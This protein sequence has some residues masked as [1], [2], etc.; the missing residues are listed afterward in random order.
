ML[1][2]DL[3]ITIFICKLLTLIHSFNGLLC[4]FLD[5]HRKVLLA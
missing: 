2:F 3:L 1:L 4:K 5:I